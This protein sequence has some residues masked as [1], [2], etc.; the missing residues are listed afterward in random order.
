M[1]SIV[2]NIL[3]SFFISFSP[4][5]PC[6]PDPFDAYPCARF[7]WLGPL[8]D[9][10]E[11]TANADADADADA[12]QGQPRLLPLSC[13]VF[14]MPTRW[15]PPSAAHELGYLIIDPL[16]SFPGRPFKGVERGSQNKSPRL[17]SN[18]QG[19]GTTSSTRIPGDPTIPKLDRSR[20]DS[21]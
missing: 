13:W 3:F 8:V 5:T 2:S 4:S 11:W 10:M 12:M 7:C 20:L 14:L 6:P 18:K 19:E 1:T 16:P 9:H 17:V 15:P 21:L